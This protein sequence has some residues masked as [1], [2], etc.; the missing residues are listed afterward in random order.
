MRF[1]MF[2]CRDT[3]D[4]GP[5]TPVDRAIEEWVDRMDA[6]G[7]RVIGAPLAPEREATA[8]RVRNGERRITRTAVVQT[9]D[10]LLGFDVLESRDLAEAIEIAVEHPLAARGVLELRAIE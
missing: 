3:V 8:V 7:R 9:D 1:M 4:P 6:S 2:V 5:A 10:V